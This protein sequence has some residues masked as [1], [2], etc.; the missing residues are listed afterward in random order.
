MNSA[1]QFSNSSENLFRIFTYRHCQDYRI[2]NNLPASK[3][4]APCIICKSQLLIFSSRLSK[5]TPSINRKPHRKK[6]SKKR[7][8]PTSRKSKTPKISLRNINSFRINLMNSRSN[9]RK[10]ILQ[11]T[12]KSTS[13]LNLRTSSQKNSSNSKTP[14]LESKQ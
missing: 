9:G 1:K 11:F 10:K 12:I 4:I 2:Q 3:T 13:V 7:F 14:K 6:L 5:I 8:K